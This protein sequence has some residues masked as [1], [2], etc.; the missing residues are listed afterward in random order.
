MRYRQ[1]LFTKFTVSVFVL[2]LCVVL[3]S[4]NVYSQSQYLKIAQALERQHEYE[5]A[6][7]VY[8]QLYSKNK[9][10]VNVLRGIRN[11]YQGL[12]QYDQLI[13]F[14]QNAQ[15]HTPRN[16]YI[17]SYLA[18]AYF[19]MNDRGRAKNIWHNHVKKHAKDIAVYRIV[20]SSMISMRLFDDAI[21]VYELAMLNIKKQYNL[22]MDIANL[23]KLQLKYGNAADHLLQYYIHNP[24]QFN[25]I[26]REILNL[27]DQK[28]QLPDI[29][30]VIGIFEKKYPKLKQ[31]QEIQANLFIKE[32]NF[33][34]AFQIYLQLDDE[35]TQGSHLLKFANATKNNNAVEYT[36]QAYQIIL[37]RYPSSRFAKNAPIQI[38]NAHKLLAYQKK[39]MGLFEDAGIEMAKA[40]IMYDSLISFTANTNQQIESHKQLG[41]IHSKFYFDLDKAI[42][43][44]NYYVDKQRDVL[45]R[46]RALIQLG[47]IYIQKNL[48]NEADNTFTRVKGKDHSPIAEFK[49]SKIL[50]FNGHMTSALKNISNLQQKVSMQNSLYNDILEKKQLL[51]TFADDSVSLHRYAAAELLIYQQKK[52]EAATLLSQLAREQKQISTLAGRGSGKLFLE[53]DKPDEALEILQYLRLEYPE[54]VHYDQVLY[55]LA[56][57]REYRGESQQ[58]LEL[59]TEIITDHGTSL[60]LSDARQKARLLKEQ[61]KKDE[62]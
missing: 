11:C 16:L 55:Y 22:H 3:F 49:R 1:N 13:T 52:S 42:N 18:E 27:A 59:Y 51:E 40:V 4:D 36:L 54:D 14:L 6:L 37:K 12:Q 10:D 47:D 62:I 17:S 19:Q 28:E 60:Y 57:T 8:L 48:L 53:L 2:A 21:E 34:S 9:N 20:A 39:D 25:Y 26:Q 44:Y 15:K 58:A 24:K 38:A 56:R 23:Y 43:H 61:M 30:Q 46:D 31:I 45:Q 33:D 7:V 5:Q 29:I 35:K 32:K 41:E 50:Y